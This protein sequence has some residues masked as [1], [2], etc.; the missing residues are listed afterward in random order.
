VNGT[1]VATINSGVLTVNGNINMTT[2][3][4]IIFDNT[5]NEKKIQLSSTNGIGLATNGLVLYSSGG[6]TF[7]DTVLTTLYSVD[8]AGSMSTNGTIYPAGCVSS[9]G[10]ITSFAILAGASI[11]EGGTTLNSKYVRLNGANSINGN[12]NITN[13][14]KLILNDV[15]DDMRL[16]LY[17]GYGFGINGGTL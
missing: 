8:S 15:V 10:N 4:S 2:N 11:T 6:F 3:N 7:K 14:S 13:N 5:F 16:Q 9:A 12:L 1:S 17:T